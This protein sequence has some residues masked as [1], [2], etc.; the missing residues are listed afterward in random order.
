MRALPTDWGTAIRAASA[1]R[2][3]VRWWRGDAAGR[4]PGSEL[5]AL[6]EEALPVRFSPTRREGSSGS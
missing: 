3:K 5:T 4:A 6:L 2:L 1:A